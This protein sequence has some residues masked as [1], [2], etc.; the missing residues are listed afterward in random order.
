MVQVLGISGS[1]VKDSNTDRLVK[2]ILEASDVDTEFVKLSDISVGPCIACKQCAH[3]NQCIINDDFKWL[4]RKIVEADALVIGTPVMDNNV[5]AFTKSF[6]ERSLSLKHGQLMEGKI[7]A[8]AIVGWLGTE[9]VREWL[10]HV[11]LVN[12]VEVVGSVIGY[13]TPGC[14]TCGLGENC[15]HSI[16]NGIQ[17][18]KVMAG[19][20]G[21]E[22]F[23]VNLKEIDNIEKMYEGYLE[24]LPDNDPFKN[25]SYKV[26][27]CISV[28]NQPNVMEKAIAIG[29]SINNKI[30]SSNQ[31]KALSAE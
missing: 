22:G 26:H 4:S 24:E 7:G 21:K 12:G 2:T 17:K 27:K 11:L 31:K 25:P 19:E 10:N 20:M 30:N 3:T 1:P 18:M 28:E 14:F 13:G 16:M 23:D 15:R 8:T 9:E 6:I 29:K 5:S